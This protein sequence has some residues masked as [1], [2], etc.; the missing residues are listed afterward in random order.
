MTQ[1]SLLL[2]APV[3][4]PSPAVPRAVLPARRPTPP[5]VPAPKPVSEKPP[6]ILRVT[7]GGFEVCRL[8]EVCPVCGAAVGVFCHPVKGE[9]EVLAH[10]GRR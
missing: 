1:L 2:P 6:A 7:G 8:R 10:R 9:V 4:T 5:P 3:A